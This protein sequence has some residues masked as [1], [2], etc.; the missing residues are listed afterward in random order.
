LNFYKRHIGDYIK[1]AGHLTLLEHGIYSRLMDVYYTREEALPEDKIARL[2]GARSKDELQALQNVL[3]EF[4][5]L[6]D[7][8]WFQGRC[9]REIEAA[10]AKGEKNRE[11]GKKGG[12]PKKEKTEIETDQNPNGFTVEN[13]VGSENNLSQT[14]D[15]RHQTPDLKTENTA[16]SPSG[17]GSARPTAGEISKTFRAAGVMTNPA[18]PRI[19]KLSEQQI[20]IETIKAACETAKEA[21][22]GETIGIGYV[23]AILERWAKEAAEIKVNG[24]RAPGQPKA[25]TWRD[26]RAEVERLGREV[27]I[28]PEGTDTYSSYANRVEAELRKQGKLP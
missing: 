12:R 1:D 25:P 24:A 28:L 19:I 18:D 6:E 23:V 26:N 11:N 22:P 16:S 20:P 21:K 27:N 8:K 10:S 9:E 7:A 14:P 3:G 2:I 4:F 13:H 5:T 17:A 15:T